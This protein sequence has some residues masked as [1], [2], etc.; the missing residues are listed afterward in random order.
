V[1]IP[2][3]KRSGVGFRNCNI[4]GVDANG[5]PAAIG[6]TAYEGIHAVG[7]KT[8]TINDP[9]YTVINHNGD[10]G[11]IQIDQLPATTGAT[12]ELHL[13]RVDDDLEA[14]ISGLLPFQVGEM[15]MML[16]GVTDQSGFEPTVGIMG[17]QQALD[18]GGN[19]VWHAVWF[20]RATVAKHESGL[21]GTP[22]DRMYNITPNLATKHLWGAPM[23]AVV[24]GGIRGQIVRGVSQYQPKLIAFLADGAALV[25]TFPVAAPAVATNKIAV[26]N[27]GVLVTSGLTKTVTTLTFA[28]APITGHNISVLYEVAKA[29]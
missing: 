2:S 3:R 11:L 28:V 13:G 9:A 18:E 25:F 15:N 23:T 16:A 24:E 21:S 4:Y 19:R 12:S 29:D 14:A 17:Y 27:N 10:D 22:E 1:S 26:F 6:I 5:Y 20:P 8:L 7:A